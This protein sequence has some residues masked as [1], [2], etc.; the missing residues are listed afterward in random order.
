MEDLK[1]ERDRD[2]ENQISVEYIEILHV[3][4]QGAGS[5]YS[6]YTCLSRYSGKAILP[7]FPSRAD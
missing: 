3:T 4:R 5:K 7:Y 6:A 1:R 2:K